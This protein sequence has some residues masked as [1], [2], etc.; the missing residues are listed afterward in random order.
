[1]R[2]GRSRILK[3]D[4]FGRDYPDYLCYGF[5]AAGDSGTVGAAGHL[6]VKLEPPPRRRQAAAADCFDSRQAA[7]ARREPRKLARQ[8]T[9]FPGPLE[10]RRP[11]RLRDVFAN[12]IR[13]QVKRLEVSDEVD[14]ELELDASKSTKEVAG[15]NGEIKERGVGVFRAYEAIDCLRRGR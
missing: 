8:A 13:G 11:E 4:T 12:V 3:E 1:M 14:S 9:P 5:A 10:A 6:Q 2:Q 15:A 7:V